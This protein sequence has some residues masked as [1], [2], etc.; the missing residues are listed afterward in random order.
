MIIKVLILGPDLKQI[1]GVA[2]YYNVLN[3][4]KRDNIDYFPIS[5]KSRQTIIQTLLWLAFTYLKFTTHLIFRNYNIIHLNPSL[6]FKSFFR[7]SIFVILSLLFNKKVIIFFHGWQDDF[8]EK[9][10]KKPLYT[11]LFRKSFA[12]ANV[13]IVLGEIFRNKLIDLGVNPG[14]KIVLETTIVDDND[15]KKIDL[16]RKLNSFLETKV[17]LFLSRILEQKGIYIAI[18]IYKQIYTSNPDKKFKMIIAGEG[19][20]LQNV[21]NYTLENEI[22][23][24]Q[25]TGFIGG[26][27][28]IEHLLNSHILLFPTYYGEGL[29]TCILEAMLFGLPIISRI[30]A[31]IPDWVKSGENGYLLNSLNP[32][33]YVPKIQNLLNDPNLYYNMATTNHQ[34]AQR[35]FTKS[36]IKERIL[37]LYSETLIVNPKTLAV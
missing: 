33:D 4:Q 18:D 9:L 29:P 21:K 27:K 8:E 26:E 22:K 37:N 16:K 31:A 28:K 14:K 23:N 25:Y 30:N 20:D 19:P 17:F 6:D 11:A 1:G 35:K 15:I 36:K 7:D 13:F 2:N 10:K 3:L 32:E 34:L 24:V 5:A 12:K